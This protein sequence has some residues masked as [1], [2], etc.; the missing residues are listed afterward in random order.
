MAPVL[1]SFAARLVALKSIQ[2]VF[3]Y[4]RISAD[5]FKKMPPRVRRLNLLCDPNG[6]HP[7]TEPLTNFFIEGILFA[8]LR[9]R[10]GS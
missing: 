7:L 6:M 5:R 9:A 2:N 8:F 10:F 3:R 4:S 1:C